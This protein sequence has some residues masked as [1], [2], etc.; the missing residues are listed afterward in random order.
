MHMSHVSCPMCHDSFHDSFYARQYP[1]EVAVV[2]VVVEEGCRSHV[3]C[4]I[5]RMSHVP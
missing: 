4:V 3:I 1:Y 5:S 2:V